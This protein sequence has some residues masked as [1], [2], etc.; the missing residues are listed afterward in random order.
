MTTGRRSFEYTAT[1]IL[2][3]KRLSMLENELHLRVKQQCDCACIRSVI[4]RFIT[5]RG[6]VR[7]VFLCY[8]DI[9]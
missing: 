3:D 4:H 2:G 5:E 7:M 6:H 8:S 1:G 9:V